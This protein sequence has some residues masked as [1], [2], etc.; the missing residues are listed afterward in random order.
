[1]EI[2]NTHKQS[3]KSACNYSKEISTL[4]V[5]SYILETIVKFSNQEGID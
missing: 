5:C 2:K 3:E 1:M 4:E